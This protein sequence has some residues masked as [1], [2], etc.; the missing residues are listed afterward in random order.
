I[1]SPPHGVIWPHCTFE[2]EIF[3]VPGQTKELISR[4][5][6]RRLPE[7]KCAFGHFATSC[8]LRSP[9]AA[10][11]RRRCAHA[12]RSLI[13]ILVIYHGAVSMASPRLQFHTCLP[14]A[15]RLDYA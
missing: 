15:V 6:N 3:G 8:S 1:R 14:G 11:W 13:A 4:C 2:S 7:L 5:V 12:Y 10:R 9:E